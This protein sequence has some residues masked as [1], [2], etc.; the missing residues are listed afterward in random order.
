MYN[1]WRQE[2][3][4]IV[5]PTY[6]MFRQAFFQKYF[7]D[8][9]REHMTSEWL[10]LKQDN[11]T[12]DE[13]EREFSRLLWFS[14]EGYREN[15][16]MMVQKFQNGLNPKICHDVNLFELNTLLAV[17]HKARVVERNKLDCKKQQV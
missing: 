13:Y 12:V 2:R 11:K 1:W 17:V 9:T 6:T 15:E 16:R 3:L 14:S 10:L 7:P 5:E 8:A 4:G